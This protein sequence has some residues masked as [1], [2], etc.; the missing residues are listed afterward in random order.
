VERQA[1]IVGLPLLEHG[2]EDPTV[3]GRVTVRPY[4]LLDG[5]PAKLVPEH[6]PVAVDAND[7]TSEHLVDVTRRRTRHAAEEGR[8]DPGADERRDVQH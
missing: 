3:G 5:E 1:R 8:S 2:R 6:E 4:L 7:T